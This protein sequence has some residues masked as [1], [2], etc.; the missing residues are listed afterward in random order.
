M[1]VLDSQQR[2]PGRPGVG[3]GMRSR[4]SSFIPSAVSNSSITS[5]SGVVCHQIA[6]SLFNSEAKAALA[7]LL[8]EFEK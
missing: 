6:L 1:H 7:W 4:A 2:T 5:S 8:A 3:G